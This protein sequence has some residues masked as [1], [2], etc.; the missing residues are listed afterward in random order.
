MTDH[1]LSTHEISRRAKAAGYS[2]SNGTVSNILNCRV[3]DVKEIT[4][5][6]LAKAFKVLDDEVFRV[7]YGAGT[8]ERLKTFKD[9]DFARLY[10]KHSKLTR[11]RQKEFERIWEMVERDYDRAL[12]DENKEA[13]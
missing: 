4:L 7:Y 3:K 8:D 11:G 2:L 10:F 9:T 13:K 12:L 5:K 6:G 1:N